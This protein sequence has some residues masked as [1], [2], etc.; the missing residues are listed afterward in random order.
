MT[1][2]G[3]AADQTAPAFEWIAAARRIA[4]ANASGVEFWGAATLAELRARPFAKGEN[5]AIALM[6]QSELLN[7]A[8]VGASW[9]AFSPNGSPVVCRMRRSEGRRPGR[10]RFLVED[11]ADPSDHG[12]ARAAAAFDAAPVAEAMVDP[13]GRILTRNEADRDVFGD[14]SSL[15]VRFANATEG[16]RALQTALDHDG[17]AHFA[18]MADG[19]RR[20]VVYRRV[21]DPLSGAPAILCAFPD[22]VE[23]D[24][25]EKAELAHDLRSP[26]NAIQGF[27]EYMQLAGDN[28]TAAERS[29]YLDDISTACAAMLTLVETLVEGAASAPPSV[30][31]LA[32]L[33]RGLTRLHDPSARQ[34]GGRIEL[35]AEGRAVTAADPVALRRILENL[36]DN[37]IRHGGALVDVTVRTGEVVVS[38]SGPGV[39]VVPLF[40]GVRKDASGR[41]GGMGLANAR[42][43]AEEIGGELV[44]ETQEGAGFTARLILPPNQT[45]D[46]GVDRAPEAEGG[47]AGET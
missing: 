11:I 21:C 13:E 10:V 47:G 37:A 20:Q 9:I 28:L 14:A 19:G 1:A 6:R 15:S 29:A 3:G 5:A 23:E 42:A 30:V 39:G 17:Y 18:D 2:A 31:D 26:L 8:G 22:A 35:R 38:D 4:W 45:D 7:E 46:A 12:L 36:I 32:D 40:R 44:I 43:L 24:A 33:A 25:L 27:A 34:A 41:T 16:L